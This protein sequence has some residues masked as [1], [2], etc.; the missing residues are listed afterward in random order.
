VVEVVLGVSQVVYLAAMGTLGGR[1]LRRA[2]RTRELPEGLLAVHFLLC[3]TVSYVLLSAGLVL[4][5]DPRFGGSGVVPALIGVG[6]LG[7][8]LGVL[9]GAAF[10]W[11]VFRP[12]ARWSAALV[13]CLAVAMLLGLIGNAHSDGFTTGTRDPWYWV[14]YGSYAVT[15]VWVAIE[16]LRYWSLVR[17]RLRLGLGDPVLVNRFL[18]WSLGSLCRVGML[19]VG[20]AAATTDVTID[21]GWGGALVLTAT[22]LLGLGV[23]GAYWLTFFPSESYL[24]RVRSAASVV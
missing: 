4:S 24:R 10:N 16:P 21:G 7:S 20:A 12:E 11:R 18:L 19:V 17:R 3:C 5:R 9:A 22:A 8:V 6:Q 1:L 15:A 2:L 23:A 14:L 13:F